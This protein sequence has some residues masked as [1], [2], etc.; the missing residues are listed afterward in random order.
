[1]YR[2]SFTQAHSEPSFQEGTR[3]N[4]G[5]RPSRRCKK[6]TCTHADAGAV[7][8]D[9]IFTRGRGA[10][11]SRGYKRSARTGRAGGGTCGD[12]PSS[13][14]LM[15]TSGKGQMRGAPTNHGW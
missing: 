9:E 1:V 5:N 11:L 14:Y 15:A 10:I 7:P 3:R 6:A 12:A 2:H 8:T 4:L 13:N